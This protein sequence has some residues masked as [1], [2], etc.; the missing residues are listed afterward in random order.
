[1]QLMSADIHQPSGVRELAAFQRS[2]DALI[3]RP[4]ER[5]KKD[6]G[7]AREKRAAQ[8][9][10]HGVGAYDSVSASPYFSMRE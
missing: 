6:N 3:R 10:R 2:R 4:G 5:E 9:R 7:A 1:M 8:G